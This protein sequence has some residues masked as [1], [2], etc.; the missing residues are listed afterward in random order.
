MKNFIFL[1]VILVGKDFLISGTDVLKYAVSVL[2]GL[3][4]AAGVLFI[5]NVVDKNALK[6]KKEQAH[7]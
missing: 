6:N 4:I 3:A 1:A 2:A 7:A 5:T